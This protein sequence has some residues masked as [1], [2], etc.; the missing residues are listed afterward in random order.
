MRQ[1]DSTQS[2]PLDYRPREPDLL[3]SRK[4]WQKIGFASYGVFSVIQLLLTIYLG[5]HPRH[6]QPLLFYINVGVLV[7]AILILSFHDAA[8]RSW[9]MRISLALNIISAAMGLPVQMAHA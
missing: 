3:E 9:I 4:R 5:F 7:V 1:Q 8:Q 2:V 6:H